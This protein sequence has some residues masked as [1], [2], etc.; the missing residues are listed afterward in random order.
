MMLLVILST[1]ANDALIFANA[2]A[3]K[4][5]TRLSN[6]LMV[7]VFYKFKMKILTHNSI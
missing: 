2:I 4:G 6:C 3:N 1:C 5:S 7:L